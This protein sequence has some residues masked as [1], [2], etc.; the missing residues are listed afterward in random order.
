MDFDMKQDLHILTIK[1][2]LKSDE[3]KY[4]LKVVNEKGSTSVSVMVTA[5]D[6]TTVQKVITEEVTE[7]KVVTMAAEPC[8]PKIHIA[9]E[10]VQFKEG[11]TITL[12]CRVSG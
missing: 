2:A 3:G 12:S 9:P 1:D 6:G 7:Q 8:E 4:K 11:E 10:P 5:K